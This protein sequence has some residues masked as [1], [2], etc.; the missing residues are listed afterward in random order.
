MTASLEPHD[1]S[2]RRPSPRTSSSA[3]G[4]STLQRPARLARKVE[5]TRRVAARRDRPCA[6]RLTN[7]W[8]QKRFP[9]SP[10]LV[11]L[12]TTTPVRPESWVRLVL[13]AALPSPAG[14][15]TPGKAQSFT[16]RV[17]R[18][19]FIDDFRC[20]DACDGDDWNPLFLRTAGQG[21][22]LHG[23]LRATDITCR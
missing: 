19:F 15:S 11:V 2:R 10:D 7:N 5:A 14:P 1:W 21:R 6:L 20:T 16:I 3:S 18:A 17:E 22:R 13:D 4:R 12:E 9:P 8:D 23:A